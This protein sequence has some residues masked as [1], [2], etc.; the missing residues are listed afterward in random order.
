MSTIL[1]VGT[2]L[3]QLTQ[4]FARA[5]FWWR[6]PLW[7]RRDP[8]LLEVEQSGLG[9]EADALND[10]AAGSLYILRG[11]RRVGK[12]V[13][14]KQLVRELITQGHNPLSIVHLAVDGWTDREIRTAVQNAALP[15]LPEGVH[16]TWLFDEISSVSGDWAQQIKWLRDNDSDFR[17]STVVLTGSH[18]GALSEAT[19]TLAGRRGRDTHLDRFLFPMGFRTFVNLMM[20]D[21]PPPAA[22]LGLELLR[23]D[24]A[25]ATYADLIPWIDDLVRLWELYLLNGG[26]PRIV[27]ALRTGQPL[28]QDFLQDLFSVISADTFNKS[29][30][31][32]STA[33]ALIER[34]WASL[35]TPINLSKVGADLDV[36]HEVVQRHIDYLEN[37]YLAWRCPQLAQDNWLARIR[38]QDKVYAVDPIIARLAHLRHHARADVDI[39]LLS[40]MQLGMG[41]RR[42][43]LKDQPSALNDEFLFHVR[44]PARKEIDFVA[45]AFAGVAIE[46]KYSESGRWRGDAAT[47]KASSWGGILATR[48]VLDI[49]DDRVWAV[50]SGILAFLIDT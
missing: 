30:L 5:N 22:T 6:D 7:D 42:R 35:G 13:T 14:L 1:R 18:A 36:S 34:V 21:N 19:G 45:E 8:D 39:T 40:E 32:T 27:A 25:K 50:P 43:V 3:G 24:T 44:T 41:V 33:M 15:P 16:R 20:R 23:T 2:R 26:Y 37:A 11:P 48:N 38:A 17:G 10:L 47:I 29:R 9:Y 4:E 49:R 28:P 12:S 46:G 31:S